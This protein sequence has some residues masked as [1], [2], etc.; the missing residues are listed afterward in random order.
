MPQQKRKCAREI[1]FSLCI[2]GKI[3]AYSNHSMKL[4]PSSFEVVICRVGF[5]QE[6]GPELAAV[7]VL[8][9]EVILDMPDI[10]PEK[11]LDEF[12]RS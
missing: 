4:N 8:A 10:L 5:S 1:S 11:N 2:G 12:M 9:A 7:V 3:W 6:K